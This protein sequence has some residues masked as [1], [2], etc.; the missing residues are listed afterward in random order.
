MLVKIVIEQQQS[1]AFRIVRRISF[2]EIRVTLFRE[3]HASLSIEKDGGSF[4]K[5]MEEERWQWKR[6]E[7]EIRRGKRRG[8]RAGGDESLCHFV[9]S[10]RE[11]TR[12][13]G[14]RAIPRGIWGTLEGLNRSAVPLEERTSP[15][16]RSKASNRSTENS[17]SPRPDKIIMHT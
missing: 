16:P 13:K 1:V 17:K 10:Y 6:L 11:E 5:E 15:F 2:T 7:R 12:R 3:H 4:A 8:E 9:M 14:R